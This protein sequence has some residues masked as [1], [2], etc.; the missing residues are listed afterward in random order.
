MKRSLFAVI[1]MMLVSVGFSTEASAQKFSKVVT[2]AE[3]W[4]PVAFEA[5]EECTGL[6]RECALE[7]LGDLDISV[8]DE[9]DFSVYPIGE[10]GAKDV[11]VVFV[12][13]LTEDYDSVLGKLYRL[14]LSRDNANDRSFR[15]DALGRMYQCMEGPSGWRKTLCP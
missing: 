13:H 6:A 9:P 4:D 3:R 15:L 2:D 12:S 1:V 11:T 5:P 7:M 10:T 14:E 8:G